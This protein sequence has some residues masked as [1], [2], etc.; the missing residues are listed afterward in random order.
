MTAINL[1]NLSDSQ[2]MNLHK[3]RKAKYDSEKRYLEDKEHKLATNIPS[4]MSGGLD[5]VNKIIWPYYFS[6]ASVELAPNTSISR[7]INPRRICWRLIPTR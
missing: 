6:T 5:D 3:E 2:L 1:R 4:L 7:F